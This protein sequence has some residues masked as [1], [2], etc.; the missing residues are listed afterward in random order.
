MSA[1]EAIYEE[2]VAN[3]VRLSTQASTDA[4]AA[5]I[6]KIH[7]VQSSVL[8]ENVM[9]ID[10]INSISQNGTIRTKKTGIMEPQAI[11]SLYAYCMQQYSH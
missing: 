4:I 1:N 2:Y 5:H 10:T 9:D 6:T 11:W 7:V 3:G 8:W